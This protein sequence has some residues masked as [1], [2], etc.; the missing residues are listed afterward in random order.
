MRGGVCAVLGM[1]L[2]GW[3]CAHASVRIERPD[4]PTISPGSPDKCLPRDLTELPSKRGHEG[5]VKLRMLLGTDGA[6]KQ[7]FVASS[8]GNP[9]LDDA[10]RR[11]VAGC[12]FDPPPVKG[13]RIEGWADIQ[14]VFRKG[15]PASSGVMPVAM[16]APFILAAAALARRRSAGRS[17]IIGANR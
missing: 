2:M 6:V 1:L 17:S 4:R 13:Q 16:I 9:A 14:Y 8:S 10:A 5:T 15:P 12:I 3:S 7:V 11:A